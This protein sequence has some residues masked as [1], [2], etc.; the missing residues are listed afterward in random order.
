MR[1]QPGDGDWSWHQNRGLV[2]VP[3]ALILM[4]TFADV[5][6]PQDIHLGPLLV[7]APALTASFGGS[8]FT[9]A[10]G[11][12]A[13]GALLTIAAVR[14]SITTANHISQLVAL[15]LIS[16]FTVIFCRLRE[17]HSAELQQVRSV[18]EAAQQAMLHPIPEGMG[19][20]RL[21]ATY[22]AAADQARIGGD[23]YAAVRAR[24]GTRLLMGDVRGKGLGAI[25]DA[26]L[27]LGAF[28]GAAHRELSLPELQ[29][30]LEST[31]VW[32]LAQPTRQDTRADETFITVVLIDIPDHIPVVHILNNGHPAPLRLH[33]GQ[34]EALSP[35]DPALPIGVDLTPA[36]DATVDTFPFTAGD[37]L[38]LYTDGASEARN[39][40]GH[41][42]P[43][44]DRLA[45]FGAGRTPRQLLDL[46]RDDL[47]DYSHDLG[48]DAAL[49]A[50]MARRTAR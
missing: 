42:Y 8:R 23:L 38:L 33:S 12:L 21:A 43:L 18:A 24:N 13:V 15:V 2:W 47:L 48:D 6:S 37:I 22:Q 11:A 25:D 30:E 28:R 27:L 31:L 44:A 39:A 10:I 9:A 14:N 1:Y 34:V 26:A 7:V 46:V 17:R 29:Q 40:Q 35:A 45:F 32:G 4:I 41:F 3:L 19:A 36:G 16:V 49:V 5:L 50:V 20:L